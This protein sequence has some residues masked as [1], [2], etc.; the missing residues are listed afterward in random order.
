[1]TTDQ[2]PDL[3]EDDLML[4]YWSEALFE[5]DVVLA[6]R[7]NPYAVGT[8]KGQRQWHKVDRASVHVR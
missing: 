4:V 3:V 1:M 7:G 8:A 5:D 2:V 6:V